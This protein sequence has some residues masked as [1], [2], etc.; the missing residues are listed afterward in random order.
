MSIFM[1]Y[2][3]S[4]TEEYR[5]IG[6]YTARILKGE[7]PIDLPV[8]LTRDEAQ[9]IAPNIAKLPESLRRNHYQPAIN[10]HSAESAGTD[11]PDELARVEPAGEFELKGIR[12]H[13]RLT[14]WLE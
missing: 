4:L 8:V 13:W 2:G 9:R 14:T 3:T 10:G 7:K 12:R 5:Q 1:S 6:A 11:C